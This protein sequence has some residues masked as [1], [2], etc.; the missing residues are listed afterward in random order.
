MKVWIIRHGQSETNNAGLWT[1]WHDAKLTEKGQEEAARAGRMLQGIRFDQVW[2]SDLSRAMETARRALPG[3]EPVTSPLLREINV[4]KLALQP[5]NVV[6]PDE[7]RDLIANGYAAYGGETHR[8]LEQRILA[9]RETL[10]TMEAENVALFTHAGWL[11]GFLNL[12][13]EV[14]LT[15]DHIRFN[16]CLV[17]IFEYQNGKWM[18]HSWMNAL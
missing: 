8:E 15:R 4:G 1:G 18:L 12:A 2:S 17:A 11:H 5:L 16:N 3:C 14:K 9:F 10:E 7:K 13:L 6:E